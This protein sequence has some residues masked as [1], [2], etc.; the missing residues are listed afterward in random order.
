MSRAFTLIEMLI[1]MVIL[2]TAGIIVSSS[3]GNTASQTFSIE[4]RQVAHWVGEDY[5]TRL[6]L[7]RR[8]KPAELP[9][10]RDTVRI[11]SAGRRF[12]IRREV[13][14]TGHPWVKRVE[15]EVYEVEGSAQPVGPLDHQTAFVGQY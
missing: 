14:P 15:V 3:I 9:A 1:A 13:K 2:A 10:G 4:R 5:L 8:L 11:E 6:R 12:E 7:E